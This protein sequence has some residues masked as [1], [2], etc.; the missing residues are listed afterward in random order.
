M[1]VMPSAPRPARRISITRAR[2]SLLGAPCGIQFDARFGTRS[3]ADDYFLF[4]SFLPH[5]LAFTPPQRRNGRSLIRLGRRA[6][7][8]AAAPA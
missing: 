2:E 3:R 4:V 1:S 8:A 5:S 6:T 7:S